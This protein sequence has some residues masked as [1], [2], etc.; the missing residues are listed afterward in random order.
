MERR[1]TIY[2]VAKVAGVAAS[3][4]S[5]A[6]AR[7]GRVNAETAARIFE[8]AR[9]LGY[10]TTA[11]PGLTTSRSR[12]LAL[13]VTDITNPFYA[14]I[15]R[16][17][18]EAAAELGYTLS[19]SHTQEDA[20]I[21]RAWIEHELGTVEGVVLASS[22]M[23]DSTI[24]MLAKQKPVVV[25]NRRLPEVP[26]L[27]VDNARGMRR[28]LEHLGELGHTSVTYLAGPE[29]SWT[30]GIRWQA[31]RE[32]GFELDMRI[33]RV[34]PTQHPTIDAGFA[35]VREIMSQP[36]TAVIAYNDVL[37]IGVIKGLRRMG[38]G[39]PDDVSVV[40]VDNILLAEVVEPELTTVAAPLRAQGET[41]VRNLVAMVGGAV[42]SR[43]PLVL[44]VTLVVRRSTAPRSRKA[45]SPARVPSAAGPTTL[46]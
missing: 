3:T 11:L 45:A 28:A 43:Q 40:G 38:V 9:E 19:L 17:A 4:V 16:G 22:R 8:A 6:F 14:E 12:T 13:V 32:A 1:P 30:D 34:G 29:A 2:D 10:R 37:A 31:L 18:H 41:A 42:S 21:E 23:S 33:R 5:R 20:D 26:C 39:V 25:L 46:P 27:L 15:I 24:R 36:T 35:R 44:P 7:P